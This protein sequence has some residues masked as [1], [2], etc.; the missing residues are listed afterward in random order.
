MLYVLL[1]RVIATP[2]LKINGRAHRSLNDRYSPPT[3]G[4][5]GSCYP[6]H[7]GRETGLS[8]FLLQ[9]YLR[10][11]RLRRKDRSPHSRTKTSLVLIWRAAQ[12]QCEQAVDT[13]CKDDDSG[14]L[15]LEIMKRDLDPIIHRGSRGE[16][17]RS[18]LEWA[19]DLYRPRTSFLLFMS[20][21][22]PAPQQAPSTHHTRSSLQCFVGKPGI[23]ELI[24]N[25]IG[26]IVG[27]EARI[28]R[29]LTELLPGV[30]AE[31]DAR[32]AAADRALK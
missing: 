10:L 29:R 11:C 16:E 5:S 2:T 21:A 4:I 17:R 15:D 12:A 19:N 31:L 25:F 18:L 20:G 23:L 28:V 9:R 32:Q 24:G 3:Y 14:D 27:R 13:F 26:V 7:N 22:L 8:S 6:L 1:L 30:M